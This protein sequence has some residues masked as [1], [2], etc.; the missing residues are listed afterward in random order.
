MIVMKFGGSSLE[1]ATAMQRVAGIVADRLSRKPVVVVS[2]MGKTTNKLLA[3]GNEAVAGSR[4][5]ALQLLS[6]LHEYH[7]REA[8]PIV[9][10]EKLCEMEEL[11][12][13]LFLDLGELA[14]GL[15]VMRELTPRSIDAISSY[16][17]RLSSYIVT[18][19]F[20]HFGMSAAHVDSRRVIV[21]D[22]GVSFDR[23]PDDSDRRPEPGQRRLKS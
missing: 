5:Q 2:A 21:T 6:E 4:K 19:A 9:A 17:E 10:A 3:I 13:A 8:R 22:S 12:N 1:S 18:L 20:R 14:K 16:G 23:D 7:L 11:V 15:S